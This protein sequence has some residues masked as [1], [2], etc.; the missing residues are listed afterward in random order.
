MARFDVYRRREGDG[1]L[2][3]C[4]ADILNILNT[5]FVVPLLPP[6][7]APLAGARLNP[8][9]SVEEAPVVM[10]TQFAA[11]VPAKELGDHVCSLSNEHSAIMNA[12]DMLLTGY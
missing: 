1:Y 4:Q 6:D 10:Y 9:F 12:L 3:D 2:L 8:S 5:R 7:E 11:S